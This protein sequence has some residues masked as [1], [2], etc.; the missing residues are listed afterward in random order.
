MGVIDSVDRCRP[1]LVAIVYKDEVMQ[2]VQ[3]AKDNYVSMELM[4]YSPVRNRHPPRLFIFSKNA[5][6]DILI[7]TPPLINFEP[8]GNFPNQTKN[9]PAKVTRC[10]CLLR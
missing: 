3:T 1:L 5:H 8:R 7:G 9:C 2:S 4:T 6:Q 10:E